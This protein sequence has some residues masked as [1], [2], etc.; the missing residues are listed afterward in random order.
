MARNKEIKVSKIE[1]Q[2]VNQPSRRRIKVHLSNG[3]NI[4][5]VPCYESFE[6]Y[7]G[8]IEELRITLPIAYKYNAW[9]HG[10][11]EE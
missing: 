11:Q 7:G 1:L 2:Y 10:D 5:I 6:Q 8:T 9:L 3:A 4:Y